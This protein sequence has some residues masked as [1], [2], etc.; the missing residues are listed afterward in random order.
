MEKGNDEFTF[1]NDSENVTIQ[2]I[3]TKDKPKNGIL[4]KLTKIN[5]NSSELPPIKK[6]IV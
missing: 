4:T 6:G 2:E 3:K 1:Q 5:N